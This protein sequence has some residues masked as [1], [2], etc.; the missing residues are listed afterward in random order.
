MDESFNVSLVHLIAISFLLPHM[1]LAQAETAAG[2]NGAYEC[3]AKTSMTPRH[4]LDIE[5]R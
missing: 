5:S 1:A 3:L 4:P 2:T